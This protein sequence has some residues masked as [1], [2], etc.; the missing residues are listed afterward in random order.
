MR[1]RNV[2]ELITLEQNP[3]TCRICR[4][5]H[6]HRRIFKATSVRIRFHLLLWNPSTDIFYTPCITAMQTLN[7][8]SGPDRI[9]LQCLILDMS[10]ILGLG[11]KRVKKL[12]HHK[13][14]QKLSTSKLSKRAK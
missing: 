5:H 12:K 10:L 3:D 1:Q 9:L 7:S 13:T 4:F 11:K 6:H 14:A 2:C 8:V